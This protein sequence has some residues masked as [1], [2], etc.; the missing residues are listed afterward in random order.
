MWIVSLLP[1]CGFTVNGC[2]QG[3]LL[4]PEFE[5]WVWH[6]SPLPSAVNGSSW[7]GLGHRPAHQSREQR[8]FFSFFVFHESL[9]Y[10]KSISKFSF[11]RHPGPRFHAPATLGCCVIHI[12]WGYSQLLWVPR[13]RRG[14]TQ[15]WLTVWGHWLEKWRVQLLTHTVRATR[16][17]CSPV[18]ST[19]EGH[20]LVGNWQYLVKIVSFFFYPFLESSGKLLPDDRKHTEQ[21]KI[22]WTPQC[23]LWYPM[24]AIHT[25]P[26]AS[27]AQQAG[28]L[29]SLAFPCSGQFLTE[30]TTN[31]CGKK[32][33]GAEAH[34]N[35]VTQS[36]ELFSAQLTEVQ[37]R[38]YRGGEAEAEELIL[39][40]F[41]QMLA[42]DLA[43]IKSLI[44]RKS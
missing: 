34:E 14:Q 7:I 3:V 30:E 1:Q 22:S 37:G 6:S 32:P 5:R 39:V 21:G 26:L 8:S 18:H 10:S 4:K 19:R 41:F 36:C 13:V 20:S 38:C 11:Q 15:R 9:E 43:K 31:H 35:K 16:L 40:N 29:V 44:C 17:G 25:W 12:G 28:T 24:S 23:E 33:L 2:P 27:C 42:Q